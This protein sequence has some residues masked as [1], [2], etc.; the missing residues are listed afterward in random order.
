MAGITKPHAAQSEESRKRLRPSKTN[1]IIKTPKTFEVQGSTELIVPTEI[2]TIVQT[3]LFV[4]VVLATR[5]VASEIILPIVL[6]FVLMLVL[7]PVMRLFEKLRLPRTIAALALIM[8]LFGSFVG[9]GA[10]LSGPAVSWAEKLPGSVPRLQE[11]LT[12]LSEPIQTF[13]RFL[14]QAE[15]LTQGTEPA[16]ATVAVQ[17]S[18][19]ND[20][21]L[22]ITRAIASG[23]FT[24]V[25]VLFFLLLSGDLFLRRLVEVLPRFKDKRQAVDISQQIEVDISGY[26]VTITIMNA[27]MGV[28]T[29]I[30]A[31][32]CGLGDPLLWGTVAFLL[33]F[34][35]VLG[36]TIGVIIFVIVGLLSIDTLW[37]AFVPATLY[38]FLHIVEGETITPMLLAKR[39]TINPVL[40]IL[41]LVFW[42]WMWGVPGAILATPMLAITKIVCDRIQPLA[43]IGHFIEG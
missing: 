18:S 30:V 21:V 9:L 11:R 24:T 13:Q 1:R 6:A 2:S 25:L 29:G 17:G 31:A 20:K 8:V 23:L 5:Y 10:A 28:A 43:A 39:F 7:Q 4:L 33:N 16:I 15:G 19:L 32:V 14:H 34:V 27:A 12:F 3:S 35:P 22:N 26:L 42:Y 41:A 36:P 38:V 37:L 40:V